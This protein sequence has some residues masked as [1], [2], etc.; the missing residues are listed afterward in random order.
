MRRTIAVVLGAFTLLAASA[1]SSAQESR[2]GAAAELAQASGTPGG[3]QHGGPSG[4]PPGQGGGMMG[5]GQSRMGGMM[6][7][8]HGPM[9]GMA[10]LEHMMVHH[11]KAAARVMRFRADMLKAMSEV[12]AK[13]AAELDKAP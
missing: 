7:G 3:H 10:H 5:P 8:Q 6:G 1:G 4:G 2:P 11:P 9:R 12:L 13:H